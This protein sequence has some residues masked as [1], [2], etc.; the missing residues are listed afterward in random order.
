MYIRP[1]YYSETTT[2]CMMQ[3]GLETNNKTLIKGLRVWK[4]SRSQDL[5]WELIKIFFV[6]IYFISLRVFF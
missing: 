1:M 6:Y 2:C 4:W 5:I 3:D